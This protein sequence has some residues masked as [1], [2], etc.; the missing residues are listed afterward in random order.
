LPSVRTARL[1][2]VARSLRHFTVQRHRLQFA[3]KAREFKET[4]A[5]ED[6][7]MHVFIHFDLNVDPTR[8]SNPKRH[9]HE[10]LANR[11]DPAEPIS[12]ELP[13]PLKRK[14]PGTVA[15]SSIITAITCSG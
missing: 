9:G 3:D 8:A 1:D 11:R 12:H 7:S 10:L 15:A 5:V 6:H 2:A 13:Q 14:P 4:T